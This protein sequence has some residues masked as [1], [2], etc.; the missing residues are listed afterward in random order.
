MF[1]N[2]LKFLKMR[3]KNKVLLITLKTTLVAIPYSL[4]PTLMHQ[5][6]E[7]RVLVPGYVRFLNIFQFRFQPG[8]ITQNLIR[9]AAFKP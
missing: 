3:L 8:I 7:S 2:G 6:S 9:N 4:A 5:N 1:Y